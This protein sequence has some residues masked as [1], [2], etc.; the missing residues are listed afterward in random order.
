M[1]TL[2]SRDVVLL[3]HAYSLGLGV[4]K[5]V[6]LIPPSVGERRGGEMGEREEGVFMNK[7]V[8]QLLLFEGIWAGPRLSSWL[9]LDSE[10]RQGCYH[11]RSWRST[12]LQLSGFSPC[13]R[14][15]MKVSRPSYSRSGTITPSFDHVALLVVPRFLFMIDLGFFPQR[16]RFPCFCFGPFFFFFLFEIGGP[17]QGI[18]VMEFPSF[19]FVSHSTGVATSQ[20]SREENS[21]RQLPSLDDM[22]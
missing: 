1:P 22:E 7:C 12:F 11:R 9:P 19:F 2:D 13:S 3:V 16:T 8:S 15:M 4:E 17:W 18:D 14:L 21:S 6:E 5:E 10:M 20:A